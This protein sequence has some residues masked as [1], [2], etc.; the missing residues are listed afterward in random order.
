MEMKMKNM[1][2]VT[3]LVE[4]PDGMDPVAFKKLVVGQLE[5]D[6]ECFG[7][8][9]GPNFMVVSDGTASDTAFVGDE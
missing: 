7:G 5:S 4:V 8:D 1:V 2:V 6:L 3:V 9:D